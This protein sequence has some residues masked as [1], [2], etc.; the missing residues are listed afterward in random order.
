MPLKISIA[1]VGAHVKLQPLRVPASLQSIRLV[2]LESLFVISLLVATSNVSAQTPSDELSVPKT[3]LGPAPP[4]VPRAIDY[5]MELG[6]HAGREDQLWIGGSIG[7]HV[8]RCW[9]SESETCQQYLDV[10]GGAAVREAES[11]GLYLGSVRWQFVNFPDRHSPFARV[12][13]GM[14]QIKRPDEIGWRPVYGAGYGVTTYLHRMVDLR[15]EG[16]IGATDRLFLQGVMAAQ[17]KTDRL[18]ETFAK[19]LRDLG[20]GTVETAIEAT[21]TA[22]KATGEGIEGLADEVAKPFRNEE[23]KKAPPAD[24]PK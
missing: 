7:R 17:I 10:I 18:L 6:F 4:F 16:R 11:A 21:D 19:R 23:K 2:C 3:L 13:V 5:S 9:L 14:A 24:R 8:G 15:V 22:I 20:R 1:R 12:F